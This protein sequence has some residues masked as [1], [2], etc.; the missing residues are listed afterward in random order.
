[1]HKEKGKN[2]EHYFDGL[3][4]IAMYTIF[5][6]IGLVAWVIAVP[7]LLYGGVMSSL[8]D[9]KNAFQVLFIFSLP[10]LLFFV[11]IPLLR[12]VSK[13]VTLQDLGLKFDANRKNTIL[14]LL[15]C[16]M[17]AYAFYRIIAAGGD[18]QRVI[19]ILI[20]ICVIGL[21]EEVLCRGIIYYEIK[22][23][24]NKEILCIIISSVIFGF[25]FHSGDSDMANLIV[26][27]PL[28]LAF[29]SMRSYTGSV[30]NSIAMHTW[31]NALIITL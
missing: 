13:K 30:Y 20:Q 18:L 4:S 10:M 24:V 27:F 2:L 21:T 26:R 3:I 9:A 7:I 16:G 22:K 23:I 25:I 19:P 29:G 28:G 5:P 17:V 1:M 8:D 6:L 14:L 11:V 15:N 12:Q 31:Y